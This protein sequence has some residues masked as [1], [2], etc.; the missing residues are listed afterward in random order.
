MHVLVC[1]YVCMCLSFLFSYSNGSC[2]K[3]VVVLTDCSGLQTVSGAILSLL[4]S[5]MTTVVL[6]TLT[7]TFIQCG[8]TMLFPFYFV[9]SLIILNCGFY[10][11]KLLR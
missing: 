8:S 10:F 4:Y 11:N 9:G 5:V 7:A 1:R 6:F 2:Y 3:T